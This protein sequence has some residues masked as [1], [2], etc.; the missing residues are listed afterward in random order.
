MAITAPITSSTE[1][2]SALALGTT[3]ITIVT[4]IATMGAAIIGASTITIVDI[5]DAIGMT[6]HT[7]VT[8]TG[9]TASITAAEE[10]GMIAEATAVTTKDTVMIVATTAVTATD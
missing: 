7:V 5:M 1:F 10:M 9:T 8:G 2:S 3:D 6:A 4:D